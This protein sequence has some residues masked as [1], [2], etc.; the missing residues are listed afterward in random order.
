MAN[1]TTQTI[2]VDLSTD[3]VLPTAFTHQND[4]ARTLEF[5]MYNYGTPYTMTG[6]TV[7]FAYKSPIV[8]GAYTVIT[9]SGMASG[10]VDGN[11]VTVTLPSAY[12]AISGVGMLT[13][14]ITPTSGTVRPV[15]IRLVV[16]KSADGNDVVAGASDFPTTLDGYV[17][18]WLDENG[19]DNF[20]ILTS[21][22]DE[23]IDMSGATYNNGY[24]KSDG[25]I[26]TNSLMKYCDY[27]EIP[28]YAH[29][30]TLNR[31]VYSS[32]DQTYPQSKMAWFYDSEY[33]LLG[34]GTTLQTTDNL[35]TITIPTKAKYFRANFSK[36]H[37]LPFVHYT[38][39]PPIRSAGH[40]MQNVDEITSMDDCK[41][42]TIYARTNS[43]K[44]IA[45]VPYYGWVGTVISASYNGFSNIHMVQIALSSTGRMHFRCTWGNDNTWSDWTEVV[46]NTNIKSLLGV[47]GEY[48]A[49]FPAE[50]TIINTPIALQANTTYK[51][52]FDTPRD[53]LIN[54]YGQ[55]DTSNLKHVYGFMNH[56]IFTNG[57]TR[58]TLN[59]YNQAGGT[60]DIHITVCEVES[61]YERIKASPVKYTVGKTPDKTFDFSSVTECFLA[62]KD[63]NRPKIIEIWEGDYNIYQEY[64][65]S[66]VPVYTGSDPS[67]DYFD[68]CVWVPE[69][70]HVIGKGIV[71]LKW[72]PNPSTDDITPNQCKCVSP[73]NVAASC[74]IENIE[75]HCKNG[76]YALHNDGLGKSQFRG[77][78]QRYVNVRCYKYPNDTDASDV[79]YGF[80]HTTGFGIDRAMHHVYENCTFF[81]T[82]TGRAFYGHSRSS[83]ITT[84]QSSPDITL[85]NCVIEST[86][87]TS[88]KF[89]NSSS[90]RNIHIRT[91]F[92]NC[93]IN[94]T[95]LSGLE[96]SESS[97]CA[98]GFDVQF[99]NCGNVTMKIND[100]DNVYDP[101]AYNTNLTL[102]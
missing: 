14:I 7:K 90:D 73:L 41:A 3:K 87:T 61:D 4:T 1:I 48:T 97:A 13:M 23:F 67:M 85:A 66:N 69:N 92:N 5:S 86:G 74:T 10:T 53:F 36:S 54:V 31:V 81:N 91:M 16:Q 71:R 60:G 12:T 40:T 15:N 95:V 70:T 42:N 83:V 101:K 30:L 99:L 100:E 65:D 59:L 75:L 63:D 72:M 89:G 34:T 20:N 45:N 96:G 68:Y 93:S 37:I 58:R 62:L 88:V 8:D 24:I 52:I 38:L 43:E 9:G 55:G 6:N 29:Y 57:S 94:G 27:I 22:S 84:E 80:N 11:K 98:N 76:R 47:V 19:G 56:V 17:D 32:G 33:T 64:V 44:T 51:I 25:T 77:S 18:E 78:V 79:A 82:G 50:A 46:T 26:G 49:S 28:S 35:I 21:A 2:R 102:Q 39:Y